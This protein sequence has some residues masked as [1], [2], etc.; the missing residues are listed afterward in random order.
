MK[1]KVDRKKVQEIKN[2]GSG[3]KWIGEIEKRKEK[4]LKKK[5][6]SRNN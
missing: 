1:G 4:V 6:N 2:Q 3:R 5:H